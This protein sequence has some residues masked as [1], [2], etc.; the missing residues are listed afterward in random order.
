[1]EKGEDDSG[2]EGIMTYYDGNKTQGL[3]EEGE[4]D[5]NE[6][7]D[8]EE[9]DDDADQICVQSVELELLAIGSGYIVF[10]GGQN[11]LFYYYDGNKTQG[12]IEEGEEDDNEDDDEEEEDDD[13]DQICGGNIIQIYCYCVYASLSISLS[14]SNPLLFNI[15]QSTIPA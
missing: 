10:G 5:D 11:Q 8:E 6:D 12:L 7:D 13:A 1:M 14:G 4:E 3:I 15:D 9:E 2:E